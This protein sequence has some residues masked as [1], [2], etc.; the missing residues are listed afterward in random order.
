M[1]ATDILR[2]AIR[3]ENLLTSKGFTAAKVEISI[4]FSVR[5]LTANIAYKAGGSHEYQFI[6]D[7]ED[8]IN[9]LRSVDEIARD[10]FIASLG[11]LIDQ[12]R[13][14]GVEVDFLN[15]LTAL[16]DKLSSN[17]ITKEA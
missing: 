10:A 5:E 15:P 12:G 8:Y 16:M 11:R 6:Q 9:G 7:A 13:E 3:L 4:N 1:N 2:E 14:V 17:I